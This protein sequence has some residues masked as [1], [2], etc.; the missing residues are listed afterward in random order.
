MCGVDYSALSGLEKKE[1]EIDRDK[2]YHPIL[3][4]F[5]VKSL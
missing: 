1:D 2:P 3:H 5:G 4:P